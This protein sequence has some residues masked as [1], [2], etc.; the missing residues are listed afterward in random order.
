MSETLSFDRNAYLQQLQSIHGLRAQLELSD[1]AYRA[2]LYRL[3]GSRSA[4]YMT[5]E[6]RQRVIT[7]MSV[8]QAL[9]DAITRAEEA[10]DL[11]NAGLDGSPSG[12]MPKRISL[13]GRREA[14]M[15]ASIEEIIATM[16]GHYGDSVRLVGIEERRHGADTVL[17]VR[18]ERPAV[19]LLAG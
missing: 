2:L 13:D 7:F 6:Q 18:F 8:H 5:P 14:T 10:R 17:E 15:E 12:P 3:T 9:D 16:R 11:L 4:K 1:E 19:R